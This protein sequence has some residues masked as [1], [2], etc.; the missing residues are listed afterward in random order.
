MVVDDLEARRLHGRLDGGLGRR[1][2]RRGVLPDDPHLLHGLRI[3]LLQVLEEVER[4]VTRRVGQRAVEVGVRRQPGAQREAD[5]GHPSDVDQRLLRRVEE[6][7]PTHEGEL[8]VDLVARG[9]GH[10]AALEGAVLGV[11]NDLPAVHPALAVDIGEVGLG[12]VLGPL[13]QPGMGEDRS[14]TWPTVTDVAFTPGDGPEAPEVSE[15][16][17][18]PVG[19]RPGWMTWPRAP[20]WTSRRPVSSHTRRVGRQPR[21][22]G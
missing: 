3:R 19:S 15:V 9:R 17:V 2:R 11:E 20:S 22:V 1:G 18:P 6:G 4:V 16:P 13:E 10:L 7:E 8:G 21:C 12:A 5:V 14:S